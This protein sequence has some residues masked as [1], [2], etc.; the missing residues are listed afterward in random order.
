MVCIGESVSPSKLRLHLLKVVNKVSVVAYVHT[1][2][3]VSV[4]KE[5]TRNRCIVTLSHGWLC[6][7]S[8]TPTICEAF[9]N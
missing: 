1:I 4:V 3:S 2:R 7:I 5:I 8:W 6:I 9:F